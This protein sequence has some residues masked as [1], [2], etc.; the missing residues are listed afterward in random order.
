MRTI[1]ALD[2]AT[3]TISVGSPSAKLP[4]ILESIAVNGK[5]LFENAEIEGRSG[6]VKIVQGWED[7]T[8]SID[9][10][11]IDDTERRKT[12]FDFLKEIT[13][14]FKKIDDGKPTIYTLQHPV[15]DAWQVRS[16]L[17]SDLKSTEKRGRQQITISLSFTEYDP[18]VATMQKR[19]DASKKTG[20]ES[21][22][23]QVDPIVPDK[24]RR[25][26]GAVEAKFANL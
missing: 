23:T 17:F 12:R 6:S 3:G 13:S 4:G 2:C 19:Q 15:F 16:V 21:S 8:I 10:L 1:L 7:S 24:T 11:L 20:K 9:L 18:L 22:V 25:G 26:L 5:L 14:V